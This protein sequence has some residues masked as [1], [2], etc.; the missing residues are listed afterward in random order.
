M[1]HFR[2]SDYARNKVST[3]AIVYSFA[4]GSGFDYTLDD[5]LTEFPGKTPEDF[6]F[7][8]DWSDRD[9]KEREDR[10]SVV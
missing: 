2:N 5:F 7:W 6:R 10:K 4:D 3:T 9:L 8:K 1:K